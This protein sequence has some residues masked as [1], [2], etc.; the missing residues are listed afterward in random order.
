MV[1]QI[2]ILD[3]DAKYT[4][5]SDYVNVIGSRNRVESVT[6]IPPAPIQTSPS[7]AFRSTEIPNSTLK[8][9]PG[10]SSSDSRQDRYA[11]VNN[12]P[13]TPSR[14]A[15]SRN[16]Q[17]ERDLVDRTPLP[18]P[19]ASQTQAQ[20]AHDTAD[21]QTIAPT[22]QAQI[23]HRFKNTFLKDCDMIT[24]VTILSGISALVLAGLSYQAS[25][26]ANKLSMMES[27][28]VHPVSPVQAHRYP[29][30]FRG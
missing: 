28:R 3:N 11:A 12:C 24:T 29:C 10:P 16:D 20:V 27:C 18:S 15:P 6:F 14:N 9:L 8:S 7:S 17:Q 19:A 22:S 26:R 13:N 2:C 4:L 5:R 23:T 1:E 21:P 25:A 30:P